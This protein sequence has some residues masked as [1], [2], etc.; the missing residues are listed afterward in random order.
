MMMK[1]AEDWVRFD[2]SGPLNR[3]RDR[4]ITAPRFEQIADEY[5][6]R[7]QDGK[8]SHWMMPRFSLTVRTKRRMEFS[9]RT[10]VAINVRFSSAQLPF[11][12][13]AL[14]IGH[15]FSISDFCRAPRA[16]G[17]GW[18]RGGISYARSR[19]RWR[20]SASA[21]ISTTAALSL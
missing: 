5:S 12:L 10:I 16:S 13:A 20:T 15:H 4:R 2:I 14:M 17:V 7:V 11:M 8:Q 21:R 18:S 6:D 3:P 9:E 19:I 1:T